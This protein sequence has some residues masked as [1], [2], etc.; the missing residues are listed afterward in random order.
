[1]RKELNHEASSPTNT[2][3]IF[4]WDGTTINQ[5]TN[6]NLNNIDASLYDGTI[7]W[8]AS[9]PTSDGEIYYWDGNNTVQIT[10]NDIKDGTPSLYNGKN[11]W[12]GSLPNQGTSDEIYYWDG[13]SITQ[14][15]NNTTTDSGPSLYND[16]IAWHGWDGGTLELALVPTHPSSVP[17][18]SSLLLLGSGLAGLGYVRRKFKR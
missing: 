15:T 7:A 5:I 14:I 1:M 2:Q 3:Q 13:I 4:Y 18:P 6:D 17:E 8:N 9:T 11:A 10:N 16:T 12:N